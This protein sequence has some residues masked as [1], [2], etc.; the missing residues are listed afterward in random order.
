MS[1]VTFERH[2]FRVADARN[3]ALGF[4]GESEGEAGTAGGPAP[5]ARVVEAVQL[6]VSELVTNA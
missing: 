2:A 5:S 3:F 1:S 6:V 4:L